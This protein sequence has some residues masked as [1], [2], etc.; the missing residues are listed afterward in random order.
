MTAR[1]TYWH[2][3]TLRRRPSAYDIATSRLLYY[4]SK[5]FAVHGAAES[6]YQRYQAGSPLVCRDWEAFRDPREVTYTSYVDQQRE[7]EAFVDGVLRAADEGDLDRALSPAWIDTLGRVLAPLRYPAHG[8]QMAAA[9]V[10][11]MAPEGRILVAAL[12]QVGDA[13]RC[14]QR[15]AYRLRQLQ[16]RHEQLLGDGRR[17]WEDAPEW[18]PLREL[19][20]R[21]LVTYD[22]GE[23][24]AALCLVVKPGFDAM[25]AALGVQARAAGDPVLPQLCFSLGEDAAWHQEWAIALAATAIADQPANRAT[26]SEWVRRWAPRMDAAAA[27]LTPWIAGADRQVREA[28]QRG[29]SR[30]ELEVA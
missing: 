4:P 3:E 22:W 1:R 12:F 16:R 20:E 11:H 27:A 7:R 10:A 25:V 2:L 28:C 23:A 14:V 9:Y 18:Q 26:L 17:A 21:L 24:F 15:L 6:W 30:L 5:G 8:L 29:W 19:I 13:M